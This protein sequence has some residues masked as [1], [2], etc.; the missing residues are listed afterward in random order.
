MA[1]KPF[2]RPHPVRGYFND[3]RISGNVA[4]VPFWD[5]HR[6]PE[7]H[8]GVRSAR[9][10]RAPPRSSSSLGAGRRGLF[11]LLARH[12][13]SQPPPAD[14]TAPACRS[15]RGTVA[16]CPFRRAPRGC[17]SRSATARRAVPVAGHDQA[18]RHE[19]RFLPQRPGALSHIDLRARGRD[20][21][22]TPDAALKVPPPW[23]GLP[24]TPARLRWR[25][26]R[27]ER[28]VRPWQTPIDLS[29]KLL[30]PE[31]FRRI[32]APGTR[33]NRQGK[34]G[35]YRFFLAHTWSTTLLAGRP[36]PTR[37]RSLRPERQR[38]P[39]ASALHDYER[40]LTRGDP[41]PGRRAPT[42]A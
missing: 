23:D 33:Q 40:A 6:C 37:S 30:P 25:V 3:P 16:S 5:R 41:R 19:N 42:A 22:G 36:L 4:R 32:Y 13:G 39:A 38:R 20:R 28:T 21:R 8:A 14:Q 26:R 31:D 2:D 27:G 24:V 10:R 15:C 9:R 29:K 17:L 35:L 7:R 11:R 1:A 18:T 34:P 12:P